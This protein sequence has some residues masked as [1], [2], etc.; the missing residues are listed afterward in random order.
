[1]KLLFVFLLVLQLLCALEVQTNFMATGFEGSL[2]KRQLLSNGG[3]R[4]LYSGENDISYAPRYGHFKASQSPPQQH[5]EFERHVEIYTRSA[6]L[7]RIHNSTETLKFKYDQCASEKIVYGFLLNILKD[8]K[9]N[10]P[11]QEPVNIAE[12]RALDSQ[13]GEHLLAKDV[14]FLN[15]YLGI[16]A[17]QKISDLLLQHKFFLKSYEEKLL[18][19]VKAKVKHINETDT[20]MYYGVPNYVPGKTFFHYLLES[21]SHL[22]EL[23][24]N[25]NIR[26]SKNK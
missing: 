1:M 12:V 19:M 5:K 10:L 8:P 16:D 24:R 14:S 23:Q 3:G 11:S 26:V 20:C 25:A 17:V 18:F 22:M 15:T 6:V 7:S 2:H 9:Q 13:L 4:P 21:A